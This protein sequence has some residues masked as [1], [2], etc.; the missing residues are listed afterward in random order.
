MAFSVGAQGY[1]PVKA[2]GLFGGNV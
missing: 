1:L 2:F